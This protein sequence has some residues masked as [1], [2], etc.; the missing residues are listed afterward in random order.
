MLLIIVGPLIYGPAKLKLAPVL[1][2]K[3]LYADADMAKADWHTKAA[4]I[5]GVLGIGLGL[6]WLDGAAATFIALGIM[7][8]GVRNAM[9]ALA[10]LMDQRARTVDGKQPHPLAD[11]ILECTRAAS[12]VA[13]AAVRIRDEGQ[14]LHAEVFVKP[15][16]TRSLSSR[17]ALWSRRSQTST[18]RCTMLSSFRLASC[19]TWQTMAG[20]ETERIGSTSIECGCQGHAAHRQTA[21][22][23]V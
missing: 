12:W 5:V 1:H 7:A 18:G 16:R 4:S 23:Q 17:W 21:Y 11:E 13:D 9:A 20:P 22:A 15:K 19:Q 8:D 2:N 6:W 3:V 14:V 10:D